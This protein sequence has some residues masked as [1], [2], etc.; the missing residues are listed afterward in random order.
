MS[1]IFRDAAVDLSS[2]PSH[3]R[4][5][6]ESTDETKVDAWLEDVFIPSA[7]KP[8]VK[9]NPRVKTAKL[10]GKEKHRLVSN[11]EN[12]QLVS[13][14]GSSSS[15][16]EK[17]NK[18]PSL[19]RRR[20]VQK[21]SDTNDTNNVKAASNAPRGLFY[22]GKTHPK[23]QITPNTSPTVPHNTPVRSPLEI[24]KENDLAD[25][26][27]VVERHR[28]GRGLRRDRCLSYYDWDILLAQD[29]VQ[30]GRG[31]DNVVEGA[32]YY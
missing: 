13:L 30:D 6:I 16:E 28:K 4:K 21:I 22:L 31:K 26:S 14:I 20:P 17:A 5:A 18:D 25:L 12:L 3:H 27:P 7:Q 9:G 32:K 15:A 11:K 19:P 29:K 23:G 8:D 1:Q 24:P 2:S 10:A